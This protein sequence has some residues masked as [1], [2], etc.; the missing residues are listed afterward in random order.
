MYDL[1]IKNASVLDGTG[2]DAFLSDVA[3]KD[4]KIAKIGKE[5]SGADKIIDATGLTLSPGW[6]DSHSHSDRSIVPFPDQREKIEQGI[7]FSITGQCGGSP[8]PV[9]RNGALQT[10]GEYISEVKKVKQG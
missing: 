5:L 9:Q 7:T 2:A 1:I 4:G 8:A 3:I 6:I 10:A